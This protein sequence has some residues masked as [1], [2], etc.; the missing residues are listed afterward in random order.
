MQPT[1]RTCLIIRELHRGPDEA[2]DSAPALFRRTLRALAFTGARADSVHVLAATHRMPPEL[3]R[4]IEA[5]AHLHEIEYTGDAALEAFPCDQMRHSMAV[6]RSL[7]RLHAQTPFDRVHISADN[8]EGYFTL[9]AARTLGEFDHTTISVAV[10][11]PTVVRRFLDRRLS[12]TTEDALADHTEWNAMS[13]ADV[14]VSQTREQFDA[15]DAAA[16]AAGWLD[17]IRTPQRIVTGVV[18]DPST[19]ARAPAPARASLPVVLAFGPLRLSSGAHTLVAAAQR[20]LAAGDEL[21]VRFVGADLAL[22]PFDKVMSGWLQRKI[23]S[24][25]TDR[26]RVEPPPSPGPTGF[27]GADAGGIGEA[28]AH[29]PRVVCFPG[30]DA[31]CAGAAWEAMAAGA[32][33][34]AVVGSPAADLIEHERTG[35]IAPA[36]DPAGLAA[37][38]HRVLSDPRL[39]DRLG[40][41]AR[42]DVAHLPSINPVP[43]KPPA[44]RAGAPAGVDR[45]PRAR[46]AG[47]VPRVTVL[48]PFYN[49]GAWFPDTLRSIR[50][51]TFTDY[52]ILVVDD[53]STDPLSLDLL[54][55]LPEQGVRVLR[56]TNGGS[57]AARNTGFRA[58]RSELILQVDADDILHPRYLE[59]TL[60]AFERD[61]TGRLAV[62]CTP[63]R[64]FFESPERP[65]N[66]GWIPLGFDRELLP[67]INVGATAS[68]LVRRDAVLSVGGYDEFL[69]AHE[70]WDL[71]CAMAAAG[72][73]SS[74]IPEFLF[75]YRVREDGLFRTFGLPNHYRYKSYMLSKNTGLATRPSLS[76]RLALGET[77]SQHDR[78]DWLAQ[79]LAAARARLAAVEAEL[80][81]VQAGSVS[82]EQAA[83]RLR[84]ENIRYRI[85]D[86]LNVAAKS[87]G[88]HAPVKSVARRFT[89]KGR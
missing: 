35:L 70:D 72:F 87:T 11:S 63:I 22:A 52:E 85:V 50:A 61:R 27:S 7:R 76:A 89:G 28:L 44:P 46:S 67:F 8:G 9:R 13:E 38:L 34:V 23:G 68:C 37:T 19:V 77:K 24:A 49:L 83:D 21:A 26:F 6:H 80:A 73:T 58:A 66:S 12:A 14:L 62:A 45:S 48:V 57:S 1:M 4:Q 43:T 79:E 78:A 64:I 86:R 55:R 81:A 59:T 20:L 31:G 53:G 3:R 33:V 47:D 16:D 40:A 56:R 54:D 84:R 65:A 10:H 15:L 60:G 88:L 25:W 36:N 29:G 2:V 51:Q 32:C 75:F 18:L 39:S 5:V 74:I 82:Y 69:P 71:W 30:A 17:R 42:S 41:T